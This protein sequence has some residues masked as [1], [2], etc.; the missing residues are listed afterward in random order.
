MNPQKI[1]L[2]NIDANT[3]SFLRTQ[4]ESGYVVQHIVS[5]LPTYQKL[6]IIYATPVF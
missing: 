2:I 4:L 3:E 1:V 6:L 5:L